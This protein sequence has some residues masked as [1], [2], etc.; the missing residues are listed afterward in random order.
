MTHR[1]LCSSRVRERKKEKAL[2]PRLSESNEIEGTEKERGKVEREDRV[3]EQPV[4]PSLMW[5]LRSAPG[6]SQHLGPPNRSRFVSYAK[7]HVCLFSYHRST[8]DT[9]VCCHIGFVPSQLLSRSCL[10]LPP[11]YRS[12]L[13]GIHCL[14]SGPS[15]RS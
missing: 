2:L 14:I 10:P 3:V 5:R 7:V 4:Q 12:R 8:L 13:F 9:S 6:A 11:V 1:C 15:P